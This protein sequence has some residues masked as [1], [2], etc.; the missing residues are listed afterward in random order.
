MLVW[1]G[2]LDYSITDEDYIRN[3][4][5][6]NVFVSRAT[7]MYIAGFHMGGVGVL[8]FFPLPPTQNSILYIN[9]YHVTGTVSSAIDPQRLLRKHTHVEK[10]SWRDIAPHSILLCHPIISV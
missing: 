6:N 7:Y 8:G 9:K 3:V 1:L 10:M 4:W 2:S 5:Q